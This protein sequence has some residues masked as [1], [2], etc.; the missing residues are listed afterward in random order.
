M[1]WHDY[2]RLGRLPTTMPDSGNELA[3]VRASAWALVIHELHF[4][5]HDYLIW[6]A[7]G[8]VQPVYVLRFDGVPIVSVYQRP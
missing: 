7:Y 1:A 2:I 4:N 5:R 8:T 3:G 6:D